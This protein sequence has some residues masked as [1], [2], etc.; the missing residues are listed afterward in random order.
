M[1]GPT[2]ELRHFIVT[3]LVSARGIDS[4]ARDDD[5]IRAGIVDWLGVQQLVEF[6]QSHY[7][8]SGADHELV[9]QNF[10]PLAR[11]AAFVERRRSET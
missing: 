9:S 3:E 2:H 10:L 4:I 7:G 11:L 8:I 5:L 6:V 1:T